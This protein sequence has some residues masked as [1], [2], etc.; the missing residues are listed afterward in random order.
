[1]T[2]EQLY[3]DGQLVD[4][5][6]GTNIV[7][8]FASNLFRDI[9][10]MVSNKTYTF[11]L[12]RTTRNARIMQFVDKVSS[13]STYAREYHK[14]RYIRGGV[15]LIADGRAT[16]L[17]ADA[18]DIEM[19]VVWGLYPALGSITNAD[20]TLNML[21]DP[22]ATI[23]WKFL[24]SPEKYA[25]IADRNFFYAALNFV[26]SDSL[27]TWW[28]N[29]YSIAPYTTSRPDP[30]KLDYLPQDTRRGASTVLN[31]CVRVS[32]IIDLIRRLKNVD[33]QWTGDALSKI[34]SLIVPL[35]TRK[36]SETTLTIN[37]RAF[38]GSFHGRAGRYTLNCQMDV[39]IPSPYLTPVSGTTASFTAQTDISVMLR[40]SGML[41]W[42]FKSLSPNKDGSYTFVGG[43]F[44][45]RIKHNDDTEDVYD[46]GEYSFPR[47]KTIGATELDRVYTLREYLYAKGAVELR[48]GDVITLQFSTDVRSPFGGREPIQGQRPELLEGVA[49]VDFS[50]VTDADMVQDGQQYPITDN[51]PE[52]KVIDFIRC[53]AAVT[54]VFPKPPR[55]GSVEQV[56][57]VSI[58][59]LWQNMARAKDWTGKLVAQR[60]ESAP[61]KI[62]YN[63]ADWAQNNRYRWKPCDDVAEG[64]GDGNL[65]ISNE[66]LNL[67]RNVIEFPFAA[68]EGNTVA[69]YEG[70]DGGF[71]VR[72]T[73]P[74]LLTLVEDGNADASGIFDLSMDDIL[75]TKYAHLAA[76]LQDITVITETFVLGDFELLNF[77]ETTPI[78]LRQYG[79]YFAVLEIK[80]G[81]SGIAE[82]Q[83]LKLK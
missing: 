43:F 47:A 42:D 9:A 64:Y 77:D 82:V 15:E 11:K 46:N 53:L 13:E 17:S 45:L 48:K 74:R 23:T 21:S 44:V 79:A 69:C 72:K 8:S 51:L 16:I 19:C 54:G 71:N 34:N 62:D 39:V 60:A 33:F 26:H 38:V 27:A 57:F 10:K 12:P 61:R 76:T 70:G 75:G 28:K 29:M 52:I 83:M 66:T 24:M 30:S 32:Y 80:S 49:T 22:S 56:T 37:F 1:M 14:A 68:T 36:P 6:D 20:V 63:L 55:H 18:T 2:D 5:N 58:D 3:I 4:I 59:V 7:L 35:T 78:Y 40:M 25:D 41:S 65:T 50:L 73:E 81:K 67:E 31:P